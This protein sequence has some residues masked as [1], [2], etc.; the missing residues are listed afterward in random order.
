MLQG[1]AFVRL[2]ACWDKGH[3]KQLPE[4]L[5]RER[6]PLA[7]I[8]ILHRTLQSQRPD[9][10]FGALSCESTAY[11]ILT[12]KSIVSLPW[13]DA[14]QPDITGAINSGQ[15]FLA[16]HETDWRGPSYLW[17]EKV[18]YSMPALCQ[19]YC[20]AAKY[21]YRSPGTWTES[22]RDLLDIASNK[23]LKLQKFF[24]SLPMFQPHPFRERLLL[25]S[26]LE[27]SLFAVRMRRARTIIFP[28]TCKAE[29]DYVDY[30]PFITTSC[31][32][33]GSPVNT[34]LLSELVLLS[35]LNYQADEYMESV[36][37]VRFGHDLQGIRESIV[38]VCHRHTQPVNGRKRERE[39]DLDSLLEEEKTPTDSAMDIEN[40]FK[41]FAG[42]VLNHPKVRESAESLRGQLESELK[43]FLLAH[44]Q[45]IEDNKRRSHRLSDAVKS[46]LDLGRTYFEWVRGTSA[47]HTSCPYSFVFWACLISKSRQNC[48]ANVKTMYLAQDLSRH[49]ATMC[50]QH[51]DYGSAARDRTEGNLNS[52]DFEEFRTNC[53]PRKLPQ[54]SED[55][56]SKEDDCD[57][58]SGGVAEPATKK[59]QLLWI[60]EYERHC[61]E[62][63]LESLASECSK[64]I[65]DALRF[66]V[67]VTDL[68]GQIYVAKDI[69]V[70]TQ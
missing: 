65:M 21:N 14:L 70:R 68:Y 67:R 59:D 1:Q 45:Q 47:D 33:L 26:R 51:N 4:L 13:F 8:Q 9:G 66:F 48:F 40:V 5:V 56:D 31:N 15:Q 20:I 61:L 3:L 23:L 49:L 43:G 12:L 52:I 69:G 39:P 22:V 55:A 60:A 29:H 16:K 50:R 27:A 28:S 41:H 11:A 63:S 58:P 54:A 37:G 64:E 7:L 57:G 62:L 10:S 36:V 2:L 24:S 25:L 30:I 38:R 46:T 32:Y 34:E 18:T 19:A 35:L 17:I 42:Y 6:V 53:A 44:V